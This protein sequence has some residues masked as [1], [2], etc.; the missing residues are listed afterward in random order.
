M[1]VI[2]KI[3][4]SWSRCSNKTGFSMSKAAVIS[5]GEYVVGS[6]RHLVTSLIRASSPDVRISIDELS[7]YRSGRTVVDGPV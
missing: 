2:C 1:T 4:A 7:M 5:V 6:L 3:R